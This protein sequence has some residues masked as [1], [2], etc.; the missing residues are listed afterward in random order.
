M[1]VDQIW[2]GRGKEAGNFIV[3]ATAS[4]L[5][6]AVG[7]LSL[8]VA[9]K[10][11]LDEGF[12]TLDFRSADDG[13]TI[14]L[15]KLLPQ[16]EDPPAPL[17]RLD[18]SS[19]VGDSGA[20]SGGS[21]DTS[22]SQGSD[23]TVSDSF[24]DSL[25][26]SIDESDSFSDSDISKTAIVPFRNENIGWSCKERPDSRF[27]DEIEATLSSG[28][29]HFV[30]AIEAEFVES[31]EPGSIRVVDV[32]AD[33]WTLRTGWINENGD[34]EI[35]FSEPPPAGSICRVSIDGVRLGHA[36]RWKRYSA[37]L[38]RANALFHALARKGV[39]PW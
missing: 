28:A 10:V 36:G 15:L 11:E 34:I 24:S 25:S 21:G 4:D 1:D 26:D 20:S 14:K 29:T 32:F 38:A 27:E 7:S 2:L 23:S 30:W 5:V 9:G 39:V 31:C 12:L 16:E 33:W 35:R 13:T 8:K 18:G 22:V 19:A 17:G 37:I 3:D 6:Q